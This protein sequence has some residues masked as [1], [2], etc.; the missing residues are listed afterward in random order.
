MRSLPRLSAPWDWLCLPLS[1]STAE[2]LSLVILGPQDLRSERLARALRMDPAL[3]LWTSLKADDSSDQDLLAFKRLVNGL[4]GL[5]PSSFQWKKESSVDELFSDALVD[6]AVAAVAKATA[7]EESASEDDDAEPESGYLA[8]ILDSAVTRFVTE[9]TNRPAGAID[10]LPQWIRGFIGRNRSNAKS[11]RAPDVATSK[12]VSEITKFARVWWT[13]RVPL[14]GGFPVL[15]RQ[16]SQLEILEKQFAAELEDQKLRAMYKLAAGAGH[17]INNPL[18]SIAGRAQLLLRDETDPERRRTLAKIN[19]QAFRAH[20]MI[21]DMMLFA[22]PPAPRPEHCDLQQVVEKVFEELR[23]EAAERQTE[24]ILHGGE[25]RIVLKVDPTQLMVALQALC[26]NS[27]EALGQGGQIEVQL[28][29]QNCE[30]GSRAAITVRDNGPGISAEIRPHIF[31]PFFS[32][33]EAGRG[34]GFGLSKTWRIVQIHG[35]EIRVDSEIGRGAE[36]TI[37]IPA[38]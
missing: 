2:I 7:S 19:A 25:R 10:E 14:A 1:D 6:W 27:L 28:S 30:D 13:R 15:C 24:L 21:S 16:M 37:L 18:G 20:E 36:F 26:R 3:V 33:R 34:L 22:K 9:S 35:G 12:V 8:S 38:A 5:L 29:A 31:D 23:V 4:S 32:G 11:H 17:E